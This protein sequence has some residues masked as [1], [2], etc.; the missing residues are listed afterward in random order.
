[1]PAGTRLTAEGCARVSRHANLP[2]AVVADPAVGQAHVQNALGDL[3]HGDEAP[4]ENG[5]EQHHGH[6]VPS[7]FCLSSSAKSTARHKYHEA[8]DR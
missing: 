2:S 8:I 7:L 5:F 4:D 3:G 6:V 1:L